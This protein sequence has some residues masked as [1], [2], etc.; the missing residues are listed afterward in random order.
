MKY[1]LAILMVVMLGGCPDNC[2]SPPVPVT[3]IVTSINYQGDVVFYNHTM[4]EE[5]WLDYLEDVKWYYNKYEN[6]IHGSK[7]FLSVDYKVLCNNG[8][9]I[10]DLDD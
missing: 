2:V 1:F 6:E 5:I 8:Y 10:S 7:M 3:Y 9:W 4:E